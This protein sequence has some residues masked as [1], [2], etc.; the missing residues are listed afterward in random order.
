MQS[1]KQGTQKQYGTYLRRWELYCGKQQIH[2]LQASTVDGLNF[3]GELY[4]Q[5]L[6]YSSINTARSALSTVI[7]QEGGGS[8]GNHPLVTKFL[9]GVYT[10]R[11]SLPRYKEIWDV[12]GVLRF[13]KTL[14]PLNGIS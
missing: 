9:R 1:W 12:S 11:P 4:D 3:L 7:I 13:L 10:T 2:P 14:M 8:F 6:A 5:N